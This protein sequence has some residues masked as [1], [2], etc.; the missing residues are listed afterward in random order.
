MVLKLK[1]ILGLYLTRGGIV[2]LNFITLLTIAAIMPKAEF[3]NFVFL[4][5]FVQVLSSV[6]GVGGPPYLL[7]EGSVRQGN[8]EK[9]LSRNEAIKI[10]LIWPFCILFL[11]S[12]IAVMLFDNFL[13]SFGSAKTSYKSCIIFL[14]A[15]LIILTINSAIPFRLNG[16]VELAMFIRDGAPHIILLSSAF[17]AKHFFV[18]DAISILLLFNIISAMFV[19]ILVIWITQLEAPLWRETTS[20]SGAGSGQIYFWG[21]NVL[22]K[23]TAQIDII[24]GGY[25]LTSVDLGQYQILKRLTNLL[26]LPQVI[27]NWLV[28]VRIGK[29]FAQ[30]KYEDVQAAC[31]TS[32][33]MSFFPA[34]LIL[35]VLAFIFPIIQNVYDLPEGGYIW[36]V[37]FFLGLGNLISVA[38][39]MNFTVASQCGQESQ[40]MLVKIIGIV[41]VSLIILMF[42]DSLTGVSLAGAVFSS[43]AISNI[44]LYVII[45]NR[46]KIDTSI[47]SLIRRK[48]NYDNI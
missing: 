29:S 33:I 5:A 30:R 37:F 44:Y 7:R 39:G 12:L 20:T 42:T 28:I 25:F 3:G 26:M 2:G 38:C 4:W 45:L 47:L 15:Y 8:P 18:L 11:M 1:G 31:H 35:V 41:V 48:K 43:I 34:L 22:S 6:A 13:D 24:I 10:S 36:K 27:A 21:S 16:R 9:G 19:T 17:L 32:L 46:L 23:L 14:S 40:I